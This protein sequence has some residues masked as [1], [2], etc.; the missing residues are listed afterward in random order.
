MLDSSCQEV[1][2]AQRDDRVGPRAKKAPP[3]SERTGPSVFEAHRSNAATHGVLFLD[4]LAEVIAPVIDGLRQPLEEPSRR[5]HS[6]SLL[7]KSRAP[8]GF[9]VLEV[10][11]HGPHRA[12]GLRT[13]CVGR[14]TPKSGSGAADRLQAPTP[15]TGSGADAARVSHPG[16]LEPKPTSFLERPLSSATWLSASL[17]RRC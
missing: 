2:S 9:R 10:F 11:R 7:P 17:R 8:T 6:L 5:L 4:E 14:R 1:P 16:R 12:T 15:P 13:A 3:S